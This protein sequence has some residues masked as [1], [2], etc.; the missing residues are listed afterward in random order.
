MEC[1]LFVVVNT[2]IGEPIWSGKG[3]PYFSINILSPS[4]GSWIKSYHKN[5]NHQRSSKRPVIDLT[6]S[7]ALEGDNETS[8]TITLRE[9][10]S[11]DMERVMQELIER[12]ET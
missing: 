1:N 12:I 11:E 4:V 3:R 8:E 7:G 5:S 9:I 10:A 2:T 6:R